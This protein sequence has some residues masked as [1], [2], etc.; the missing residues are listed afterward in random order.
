MSEVHHGCGIEGLMSL[1]PG[2]VDLVLSDL[3]SGETA[4]PFDKEP[5]MWRLW[6]ATWQAL[7]PDGIAVLMASSLRFALNVRGSSA[8]QFRYDMIW[9]KSTATG[10]FNADDRPLR[11]HEFILVFWRETG[12]FNP[13][14]RRGSVPISANRKKGANNLKENSGVNY[15]A[16]TKSSA[17]RA[18]QLD[19]YPC[20][21]LE[22]GSVP[23]ATGRLHPQQKP[24]ALMAY[25][26][27]QYS[28]PGDLVV[29]PYAG[30]GTTIQAALN[31]G[32]RAVGFETNAQFVE[33]ANSRRTQRGLFEVTA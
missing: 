6:F 19:R 15:G 11:S 10:H 12:T 4:A 3:P 21:V 1:D 20:S 33:T 14:M 29:D 32:R 8:D 16:N 13:Q 2:S 9:R 25:L 28:N 5:D 24:E 18:G 22:F 23:N 17:S 27:R 26:V 7:K 31:E 30:S